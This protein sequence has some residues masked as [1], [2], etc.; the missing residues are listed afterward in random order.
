[1][2][3]ESCG[4]TTCQIVVFGVVCTHRGC[5]QLGVSWSCK[6]FSALIK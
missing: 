2:Q 6:L 5:A 1:M 4:M 3:Y